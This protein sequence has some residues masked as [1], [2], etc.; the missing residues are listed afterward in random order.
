MNIWLSMENQLNYQ[1][2]YYT[3]K[4]TGVLPTFKFGDETPVYYK[5][6]TLEELEDFICKSTNHI[7]DTITDGW[8]M[9]DSID[10]TLYNDLL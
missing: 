7:M 3:A 5:F 9:K 6:N 8:Q 4:L 10:F 1:N 2:S